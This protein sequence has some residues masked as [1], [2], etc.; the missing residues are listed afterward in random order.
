MPGHGT[1]LAVTWRTHGKLMVQTRLRHGKLMATA[2]HDKSWEPLGRIHGNSMATARQKRG[3][4]MVQ[5]R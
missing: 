1:D 5:T 4:D 2:G 3:N